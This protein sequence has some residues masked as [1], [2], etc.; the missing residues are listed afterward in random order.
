MGICLGHL[1]W[2]YLKRDECWAAVHAIM[3]I[4]RDALDSLEWILSLLL[5]L[6]HFLRETRCEEDSRVTV[7]GDI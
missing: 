1:P 4:G 2:A 3:G 5:P 6:P 7:R